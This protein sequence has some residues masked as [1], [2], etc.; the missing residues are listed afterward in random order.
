MITLFLCGDV[1]TGRGIDQRLAHPGDPTLYE[2]WVK[3]ARTYVRLAEEANGEIPRPMEPSYPWGVALEELERAR[4]AARIVN[5]ETAITQGREPWLAKGIHYRMSPANVAVLTAARLDVCSLANNHVL[6]WGPE[7]LEE[8]LDTLAEAGIAVAGAGRDVA[9][10][11]APAVIPMPS[12]RVLVFGSGAR[13]S[14][15]PAQWRATEDRAGVDLLPEP[16]SHAVAEMAIRVRTRRQPGDLVVASIHWGGNWGHDVPADERELAHRLLDEAGVHVVQGH[17]SHHVKAIEVH[18]GRLILHG[19]GD[20]LTDYEGIGGQD[21][22][23]GG[24]SLMYFPTLDPATGELVRLEMTP[25][26]MR[27]FRIER[28]P[29]DDTQWLAGVLDREGERFGTSVEVT[30]DGRL[31]LVW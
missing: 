6:D 1:M 21:S 3:D 16:P 31:R 10:A 4:P 22:F 23:R 19:C 26:R 30:E 7:G 25:T 11:K 28:A 15:I 13:S 5:L 27:R 24:L 20:F 12:G 9:R 17:S 29:A 8:T 14:G 2:P 18:Q